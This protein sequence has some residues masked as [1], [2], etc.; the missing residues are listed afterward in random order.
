MKKAVM[1]LSGVA[2]AAV[3]SLATGPAS[4]WWGSGWGDDYYGPWGGGPWYGYPGYGYGGYPGYGWGGYPGYGYGGYP[5]YGWGG[6]PGYGW[7][8]PGYGWGYP[9]YGYGYPGYGW[10]Y[11]EPWP[12]C[13]PQPSPKWR[14]KEELRK[15]MAAVAQ[16][17][18]RR[19][20]SVKRIGY[21]SALFLSTGLASPRL[22]KG[23]GAG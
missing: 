8:N 9:G 19:P 17:S 7:G 4:A 13:S 14:S 11:P 10:G 22:Q 15:P 5:G 1:T 20:P 3:L 12:L 21:R 23:T 6:Y 16:G 2:L 18:R